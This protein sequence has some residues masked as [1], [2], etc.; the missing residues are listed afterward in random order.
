MAC[1]ETSRFEAVINHP[2]HWERIPVKF[3]FI[4]ACGKVVGDDGKLAAHAVKNRQGS[5][6]CSWQPEPNYRLFA[7][8]VRDVL[9]QF[10]GWS[11]TV[12]RR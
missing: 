9:E 8:R 10:K 2:F 3:Y 4:V 6:A 7:E 12:G 1:R 5:I 11:Q